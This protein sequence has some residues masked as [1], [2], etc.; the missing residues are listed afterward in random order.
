MRSNKF[1]DGFK[2]I[3][4]LLAK[5]WKFGLECVMCRGSGAWGQNNFR[6]MVNV[7]LFVASPFILA[8][9]AITTAITIVPFILFGIG[10][11]GNALWNAIVEC[12]E[13]RP[14]PQTTTDNPIAVKID[15]DRKDSSTIMTIKS[16]NKT[17]GRDKSSDSSELDS[18]SSSSL[19][20]SSSSIRDHHKSAPDTTVEMPY[21]FKT[22]KSLPDE[23][24]TDDES[25]TISSSQNYNHR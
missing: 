6:I 14:L 25:E 3:G 17:K 7:F 5:L 21:I 15:K 8:A 23:S 9:A 2:K 11:L 16:T 24:T 19:S 12:H 22:R 20:D 1:F 10:A 13:N 18:D 4:E